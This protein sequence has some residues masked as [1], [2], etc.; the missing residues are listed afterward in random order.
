MGVSCIAAGAAD[1]SSVHNL[2]FAPLWCVLTAAGRPAEQLLQAQPLYICPHYGPPSSS[3]FVECAGACFCSGV[4]RHEDCFL[5]MESGSVL[6]AGPCWLGIAG[7][8][9]LL[10]MLTVC[11]EP[12][13]RADSFL[14]ES[15][16]ELLFIYLY[17]SWQMTTALSYYL[18]LMAMLDA[19][20][21][22]SSW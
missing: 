18:F 16:W 10:A 6:S 14:Y 19:N 13:L 7:L 5:G 8:C 15:C 2:C 11:P 21:S 4:I 1:Q 9:R 12:V 20:I 17:I 3:L 22:R